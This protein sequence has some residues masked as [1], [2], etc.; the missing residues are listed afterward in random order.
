M[1]EVKVFPMSAMN[2]SDPKGL[3]TQFGSSLWS[4]EEKSL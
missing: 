3:A 1:E 2:N 4:S